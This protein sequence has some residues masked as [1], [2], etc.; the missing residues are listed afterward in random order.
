MYSVSLFQ[1]RGAICLI[2]IS[3]FTSLVQLKC[4][5]T[6]MT[7]SGFALCFAWG[8]TY[9]SYFF[10]LSLCNFTCFPRMMDIRL[11]CAPQSA[12]YKH[13]AHTQAHEYGNCA[14]TGGE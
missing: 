4:I 3:M 12:E 5:I 10:S 14:G 8:G 9:V 2:N 13:N 7:Q 6:I 11:S 1:S